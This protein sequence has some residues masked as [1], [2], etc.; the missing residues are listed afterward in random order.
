MRLIL[1]SFIF[2][3][4]HK[5]RLYMYFSNDEFFLL[6]FKESFENWRI[7]SMSQVQIL[8]RNDLFAKIWLKI[9]GFVLFQI[10]FLC[11]QLFQRNSYVLFSFETFISFSVSF[12]FPFR[13][14]FR[15]VFRSAPIILIPVKISCHKKLMHWCNMKL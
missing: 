14:V 3:Q 8:K 6:K 11:K 15:S 1:N 2:F 4:N 13:S 10:V 5:S 9:K 7:V 12:R